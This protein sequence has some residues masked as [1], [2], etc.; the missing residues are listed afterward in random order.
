MNIFYSRV[1]T[2]EQNLERQTEMARNLKIDKL[3]EEKM[4]GK[5]TD[6]PKLN[7][8]LD[9]VREGDT[10]YVESISRLSRSIVDLLKIMKILEDKKVKF[11]SLK[12]N[13]D[14][15]TPQGRFVLT[16]FGA[17]A[18]LEREQTLQRQREGIAIAKAQG[19]YKGRKPISY[20]KKDFTRY[21]KEWKNGEITARY[22][23]N[24]LG[25]KP[26]TFYRRVKDFE[27][28]AGVYEK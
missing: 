13:I 19:K 11:V 26:N 5:N 28:E 10:I 27:K 8:M 18:E 7:E 1:S 9:F 2:L 23:M 16:I 12:E 20:D 4:S 22:F 14:T 21:Y 17:L 6:R 25:L 15:N 3:Y 24:K